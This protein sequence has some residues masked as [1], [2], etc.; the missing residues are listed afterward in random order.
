MHFRR[1]QVIPLLF[2][3]GSTL[4]L[5]GLGVWQLERLQWKNAL[6]ADID[7][8]QAEPAL[9]ELPQDLTHI[10]YR[11][12]ALTGNFLNDKGFHEAG[13]VQDEGPGY[14][15]L[16]PFQLDDGRILLVNRGF[17][18]KGKEGAPQGTV[19]IHGIVRE[20]RVK[21]FFSPGNSAEK[22]L[23]FYEDVP[24]MSQQSGVHLLPLIVE[25][26]GERKK[27]VYPIPNTGKVTMRNDHLGYAFTWFSIALIGLIMFGIYH[28][29]PEERAKN[30]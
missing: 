18:P 30:I 19:T 8:A 20:P 16:T 12:V 6:V 5:G 28:R 17:A 3:L 14:F 2:I 11:S 22:N 10:D 15:Y 27:D 13:G 26:T 9:Q 24:A 25:E 1:P 29:I 23:W 7:K 4:L 21:R